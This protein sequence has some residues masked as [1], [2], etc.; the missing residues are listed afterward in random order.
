MFRLEKK[1]I[2]RYIEFVALLFI[3]SGGGCKKSSKPYQNSPQS[4]PGVFA[5]NCTTQPSI[6]FL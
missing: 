2:A 3:M 6:D 1:D 5:T 4:V